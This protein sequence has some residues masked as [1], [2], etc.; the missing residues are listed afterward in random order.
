MLT[1]FSEDEL[2]FESLKAGASGYLLKRTPPAKLLEA[3]EEVAKGG[4]PMTGS[5]ARRIVGYFH[6]AAPARNVV[7]NLTAREQQVIDRLAAGRSYK[8]IADALG[9][10][11]DT[12]RAHIRSIYEKLQV[13]S[14]AEAVARWKP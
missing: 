3:I 14:R 5:V 8:E 10:S 7:E 12:V 1:A 2:I 13:H 9:I 11:Y 6:A 4:S